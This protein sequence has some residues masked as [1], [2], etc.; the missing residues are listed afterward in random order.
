MIASE[1]GI[2]RGFCRRTL[3]ENRVEAELTWLIQ[4]GLLRR[5]V[6][7]QGITDGFRLTPLAKKILEPYPEAQREFPSP[8]WLDRLQNRVARWFAPLASLLGK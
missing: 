8:T 2:K 5:E 3:S 6:D 1:A 4:V 7:G